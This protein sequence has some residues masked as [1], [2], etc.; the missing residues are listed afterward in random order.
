MNLRI[1]PNAFAA[2]FFS[3]ASMNGYSNE[4]KSNLIDDQLS[5]VEN[6]GQ[7]LSTDADKAL[8]YVESNH[9]NC[10]LKKNGLSYV[11]KGIN[12]TAKKKIET[13]QMDL[14]FLNANADVKIHSEETSTTV[15]NYFLSHCPQGI[16]D[17]KN[18]HKVVY[19]N[20]YDKID[21]VFYVADGKVVPIKYDFIVKPGGDP[22]QIKIK[23]IGNKRLSLKAD[24]SLMAYCPLGELREGKPFT[25]QKKN[26]EEKN[27]IASS[28]KIEDKHVLTFD[29]DEYNK[30]ENLI[31]DPTIQWS[32]YYGGTTDEST[33]CYV[34]TDA[35]GNVYLA[36]NTN[37]ASLAS[38]GAAQTS[39]VGTTNVVVVKFNSGG[40]R[41]WATYFGGSFTGVD[42]LAID[43]SG[44]SIYVG[45]VTD[46]TSGIAGGGYNNTYQTGGSYINGYLAKF[47][48]AGVKQWGTY[49]GGGEYSKVVSINVDHS[50]DVYLCGM[51]QTPTGVATT[52]TI[53]PT[54]GP[55]NYATYLVKFTPNGG[56]YWGTY[57]ENGGYG[58]Y[59]ATDS[60][61]N[62]Y[63]A[64][65]TNA[66]SGIS[67]GGASQ[68][69]LAG[70][71]DS[72]LVKINSAGTSVIWGT[73]FGGSGEERVTDLKIDASDN[74][75]FSGRT[76]STS[77]IASGGH[78][79][80]YG[81]GVSDGYLVK[82]NSSGAKQ[83]A[84]YYGG[85]DEEYNDIKVATYADGNVAL[86]GCTKSTNNIAT[87]LSNEV[88]TH[89][90]G[91]FDG[92][93]AKFNS[94]GV[95][96]WGTY[97]GG[98]GADLVTSLATHSTNL[99][100]GGLTTSYTGIAVKGFQN[101]KSTGFDMF[102]LKYGPLC[103]DIN[104][105]G[106]V[107]T[108]DLNLLLA[109]FGTSCPGGCPEDINGDGLVSQVDMNILLGQFGQPCP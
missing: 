39:I 34:V 97:L 8:Y 17:V 71:Y 51:T 77:G 11:W 41:Q 53:R 42:A 73:Y 32:T 83:W 45:G 93:V 25:Y 86:G 75:Y 13:Y 52:G 44:S 107:S 24:G 1:F 79:N 103:A 29:V 20:I 61:N 68:A 80:S 54:I 31:I 104:G 3:L 89:Q 105:D 15:N 2:L 109:K 102:V 67:T 35:A 106:I 10:F 58:T 18:F 72:F 28:Y 60:Q 90:G 95:R 27:E 56:R 40:A 22:K 59:V 66:I 82:F 101:N 26:E 69:S 6:K 43:G 63:L 62:V 78:Q 38:A 19:E 7:L 99:L 98:T 108:A 64:G 36:G 4:N 16:L 21:L 49:Y 50:N 65:S 94:S 9:V 33:P 84:T 55:T 87:A 74:I 5:F 30:N 48:S 91:V 37:S 47:S 12:K 92:F 96:Q 81:G 57:F 100:A 76:V 23:Y 46:A 14:E 70:D 85:S 88:Q